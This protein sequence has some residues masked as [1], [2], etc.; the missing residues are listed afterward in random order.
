M[1]GSVFFATGLS[2]LG[3]FFAETPSSSLLESQW[4]AVVWQSRCPGPRGCTQQ[5]V[6]A[7]LAE[8]RAAGPSPGAQHAPE[9]SQGS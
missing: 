7:W 4:E 5:A 8:P 2:G 1:Q 6:K 9:L 3:I